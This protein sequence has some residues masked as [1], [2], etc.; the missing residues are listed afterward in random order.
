MTQPNSRKAQLVELEENLETDLAGGKSVTVQF[1]PESLKLSFANQ[2]QNNS[3]SNTGG[4]APGKA[5]AADQS[6][7]TQGRQFIGAG[8]TKLAVQLWF[9]AT[10]GGEGSAPVDD[11]RRLTQQVIYF[12]KGKPSKADPSKFL[13]PGVRFA[14]GSF[15]FKGL[16]DG[17]EETIDFFSPDGKPLRATISLT[18]SQQTILISDFGQ[19]AAAAGRPRAPGTAPMTPAVAGS[20]LQGLAAAAGGAGV[21]WQSIAAANGIENPRR[22]APGQLLDLAVAPP[23]L[24][25]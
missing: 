21:D 23:R 13:P 6:A 11:V 8:T 16:I 14:W 17:I 3:T 10:A 5:G 12:M 7:G 24:T 25:F 19:A 4:S 2:I 9:D 18:L 1:N 20:T 15:L 22:L